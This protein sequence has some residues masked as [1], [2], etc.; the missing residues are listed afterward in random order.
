M[1]SVYNFDRVPL[2]KTAVRLVVK[3]SGHLDSGVDGRASDHNDEQHAART[4]G[5]NLGFGHL[6]VPG[7]LV[8]EKQCNG[9]QIERNQNNQDGQLSESSGP[10]S[11]G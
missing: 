1:H 9:K 2:E 3:F 5:R 7:Q 6:P 10:A 4:I 8:K 11:A